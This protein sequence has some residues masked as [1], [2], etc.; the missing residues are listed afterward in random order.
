VK[1]QAISS[2]Q[3]TRRKARIT[4]EG[5]ERLAEKW[6]I[7]EIVAHLADAELVNH[8]RQIDRILGGCM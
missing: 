8:L 1:P 5:R 6:S 3:R 4:P 2:A 7:A